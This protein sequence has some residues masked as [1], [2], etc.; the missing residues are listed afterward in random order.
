VVD[1]SYIRRASYGPSSPTVGTRG[2]RTREQITQAASLDGLRYGT[3]LGVR[4]AARQQGLEP[5]VTVQQV[6]KEAAHGRGALAAFPHQECHKDRYCGEQRAHADGVERKF[7][8]RGPVEHA[9]HKTGCGAYDRPS[10]ESRKQRYG[11]A[12]RRR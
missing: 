10:C 9:G 8:A 11:G 3:A 1:Q 7:S 6:V 4:G 5:H 2:A 12:F